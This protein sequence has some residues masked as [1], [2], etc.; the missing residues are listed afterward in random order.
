MKKTNRSPCSIQTF[1]HET[2]KYLADWLDR[3]ISE[4]TGAKLV[5]L[6]QQIHILP[7]LGDYYYDALL[8]TDV[9]RWIDGA[10]RRGWKSEKRGSNRATT[11]TV[12]RSYSP[13]T[14]RGWFSRVPHDDT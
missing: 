12:R 1:A 8:P 14:V 3:P 6:H 11:K 13:D 5:E 4:L 10:L 7:A 2:T 9:Q